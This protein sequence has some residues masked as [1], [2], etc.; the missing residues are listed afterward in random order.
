MTGALLGEDVIPLQWR[1]KCEGVEDSLRQ[2][3]ALLELAHS[4]DTAMQDDT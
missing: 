1:D 2:A 4:N 3:E